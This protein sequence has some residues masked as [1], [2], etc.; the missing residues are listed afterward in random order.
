M[1]FHIKYTSGYEKVHFHSKKKQNKKL[2][3]LPTHIF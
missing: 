2:A 1:C 3:S